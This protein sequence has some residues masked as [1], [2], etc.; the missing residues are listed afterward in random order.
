MLDRVAEELGNTRAVAR[1]SY[2]DPRVVDAFH[3]G[4]TI[5]PVEESTAR[6]TVERRVLRLLTES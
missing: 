6:R 5:R 3:G 4:R 2:V 1:R